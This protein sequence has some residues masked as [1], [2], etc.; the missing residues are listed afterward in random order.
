MDRILDGAPRK[1]QDRGKILD[2]RRSSVVKRD[3]SMAKVLLSLQGKGRTRDH[4]LVD[5]VPEHL[6]RYHIGT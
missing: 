5:G 2:K 3:P 4:T 6:A 1:G